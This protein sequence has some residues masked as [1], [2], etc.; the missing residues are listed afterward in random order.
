MIAYQQAVPPRRGVDRR[1]VFPFLQA[2]VAAV[3]LCL[4]ATAQPAASDDAVARRPVKITYLGNAGWQIDDGRKIILVDPFISEFRTSQQHE[5]VSDDDPIITPWTEGI[6]AHI[7][8]ADY[9]LI[10]HGH[11]DHMLDAP[12]IAK[13][14]GAVIICHESA[15]NIAR[16]YGVGDN[17]TASNVDIDKIKKQ[18]LIVVRGGEDFQ[19]DGF[20]LE[21]IPS[22]HTALFDKRYNDG[23]WAGSTRPGL[24]APLHESD[25]A[26]GGTLIYLLR[27]A[28]HQIFIMGSMN[29]IEHNIDGLRPDIAIIGAGSGRKEIYDYAPRLMQA[30]GDPPI[31]FPTHWDDYAI[32]PRA[33]ALKAVNVFV[34]EVRAASPQTKVIVPDYFAPV[35]LP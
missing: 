14:T 3:L 7:P 16:A 8:R 6:D 19:F 10:T 2:L 5:Q 26:E 33:E 27:I 4:L 17:F 23:F 1:A 31:V 13:K 35:T 28:G 21:V 9:I 24:K 32:K 34:D 20:S 12:Y 25:Y 29:Y 22:L 11:E 18:Q 30:L 15:A